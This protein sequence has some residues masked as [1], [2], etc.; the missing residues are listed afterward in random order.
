[1]ESRKELELI[2][3]DIKK[4]NRR[5]SHWRRR[6]RIQEDRKKE[7]EEDLEEEQKEDE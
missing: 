5:I 7:L 3:E 6:K 2:H 4:A 1:M